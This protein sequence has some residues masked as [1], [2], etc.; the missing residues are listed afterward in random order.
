VRDARH[1]RGENRHD[2]AAAVRTGANRYGVL[3]IGSKRTAAATSD[4][5]FLRE[6]AEILSIARRAERRHHAEIFF[7]SESR[8]VFEQNPNAK[9]LVDVRRTGSSTSTSRL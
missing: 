2:V 5:T 1:C 9:M 3:S 4:R 7:S 6:L 8:T